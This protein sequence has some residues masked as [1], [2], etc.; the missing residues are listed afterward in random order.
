[1]KKEIPE[2]DWPDCPEE[3]HTTLVRNLEWDVEFD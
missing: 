3:F 2:G 1:M